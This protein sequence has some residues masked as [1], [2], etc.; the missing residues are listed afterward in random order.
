MCRNYHPFL[1]G[2]CHLRQGEAMAICTVSVP[3]MGDKGNIELQT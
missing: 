2:E 3:R 1:E